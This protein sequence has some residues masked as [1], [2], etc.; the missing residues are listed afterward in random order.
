[1]C[2]RSGIASETGVAAWNSGR[3]NEKHGEPDDHSNVPQAYVAIPVERQVVIQTV[4]VNDELGNEDPG[5]EERQD[6]RKADPKG[7]LVECDA[8]R[9]G[10]IVIA[11]WLDETL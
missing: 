5:V 4:S 3:S 8:W 1:M 6:G 7:E 11:S 9:G 2:G 10:H